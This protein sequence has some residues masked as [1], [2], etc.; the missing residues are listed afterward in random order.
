MEAILNSNKVSVLNN[1]YVYF[2]NINNNSVLLK[3]DE[4]YLVGLINAYLYVCNL[5]EYHLIDLKIQE[6]IFKRHL[7]F[8]TT[9]ILRTFYQN[10]S[11]NTIPHKVLHS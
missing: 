8:F 4:R 7:S 2:R 10:D 9:Q 6:V 1:Y 5:F 11:D 3:P